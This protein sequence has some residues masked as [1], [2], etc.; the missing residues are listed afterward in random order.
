MPFD[1][2]DAPPQWRC[3]DF[4]SDLHLQESEPANYLA[5]QHY[6]AHTPADA[7][8]ILGDLFEAW[9]GDDVLA[10][11][12]HGAFEQQCCA[13]LRKVSEKRSLYFMHGNRDF[14]VGDAAARACGFQMLSDP[15]VLLY[16]GQRYL[17]SHGD[18]LCLAD[19]A[20]QH[21]R[22][23]VRGK[24]WQAKFLA[25][26]LAERLAQARSIRAASEAHKRDMKAAGAP[27]VDV[28]QPAAVQWMN[29]ANALHFIHGHTHEGRDHA[30]VS[31]QGSG[32][33]HVLP[34]W[35]VSAQPARGYVLRL[36]MTASEQ[37]SVQHV[38]LPAG[39]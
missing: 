34:D 33:R 14:L 13:A 30:V 39:A 1:E 21:F 3:V 31:Q 36:T 26:P 20:Y 8:F 10:A 27:W 19:T 2:I 17:L 4:I 11:S 29:E 37:A 28:D 24:E 25:T 38:S 32:V 18:A 9:V 22:T 5:W 6:L 12:E 16:A 15:T 7:V 23:M 35:D